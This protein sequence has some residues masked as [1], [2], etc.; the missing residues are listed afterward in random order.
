MI[1]TAVPAQALSRLVYDDS[2]HGSTNAGV[3]DISN[4]RTSV[5]AF[6]ASHVSCGSANDNAN[7][8]SDGSAD[9]NTPN[10]FSFGAADNPVYTDTNVIT[11]TLPHSR[12]HGAPCRPSH[13]IAIRATRVTQWWRKRQGKAECGR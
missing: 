6:G 7:G 9:S 11:R 10:P 4:R 1:T 8:V 2:T 12:T 3:Y 5:S 13:Q